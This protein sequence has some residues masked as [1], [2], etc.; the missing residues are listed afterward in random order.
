MVEPA[1]TLALPELPLEE[2]RLAA[3]SALDTLQD[4]ALLA[5]PRLSSLV[6][7]TTAGGL[8][9]APGHISPSKVV[10]TLAMTMLAVAS[11][12]TFNSYIERE[13]DAVMKRTRQRPLP[14]R[15]ISP[16]LALATACIES[17]IALPVLWWAVNPLAGALA[18]LAVVSYAAIYTPMKRRSATAVVVGALPGAIPPLLGWAAVTGRMNAGGLALFAVMFFW[19]LPHFLAIALYLRDDYA[20]AGI[21]VMPLTLGNRATHV[22]IVLTTAMLVPSTLVLTPL[23]VAGR[24]YFAVALVSGLALFFWSLTGI[25]L[26]VKTSSAQWAR[27][28]FLGTIAYLTL[29]FVTLGLD[30]A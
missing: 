1:A 14:Q 12:N 9:L 7:F 10:L 22:W 27:R 4:L 29:I 24:A 3:R 30:A 20:R 6:L 28:L 21:R 5:K 13:L 19:Q 15:R 2:P 25:E 23:G 16:R 18:A 11:A 26:P 17:V 8:W